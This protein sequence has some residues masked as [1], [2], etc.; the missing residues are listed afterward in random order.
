M[1]VIEIETG[2]RQVE[3]RYISVGISQ[4]EAGKGKKGNR[5]MRRRRR[6]KA[7]GTRRYERESGIAT[8]RRNRLGAGMLSYREEN[9]EEKRDRRQG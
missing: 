6:R 9:R 1:S 7:K 2:R 5:E 8:R 3:L 4:S